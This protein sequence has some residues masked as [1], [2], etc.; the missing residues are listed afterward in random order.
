MPQLALLR[1]S[2]RKWMLLAAAL[3]AT[4]VILACM[5][6]PQTLLAAQ[7]LQHQWEALHGVSDNLRG[8]L[9]PDTGGKAACRSGMIRTLERAMPRA[10]AV[11]AHILA[12]LATG[13]N[14]GGE[15]GGAV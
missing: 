11:L 15:R 2:A 13:Q 4:G 14:A 10:R 9:A 12:C 1:P 6:R 8:A 7:L 3:A 5:L